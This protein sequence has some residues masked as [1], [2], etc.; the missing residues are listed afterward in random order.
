MDLQVFGMTRKSQIKQAM[1][2][3]PPVIQLREPKKKGE[4][5]QRPIEG[6]IPCFW[7]TLTTAPFRSSLY[8]YY[9]TGHHDTEKDVKVRRKL[10]MDNPHIVTFFSA[11][12]I[13]LIVKY[14][15][16]QMLKLDDYFCVYEWGGGGVMHLHCILWNFESE[17]VEEFDL[18]S[19]EAKKR[20][21]KRLVQRVANF[22]N[23]HVSEWN[24]GKNDDGSWK[25][26]RTESDSLPHPASISKK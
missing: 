22:F 1:T 18:D 4:K 24:F 7:A 25:S 17:H 10:A 26:L 16:M 2:I 20:F 3:I 23:L 9:I 5:Q 21:S 14:L 19:Y 8:A 6:R 11:I 13:E 15:M 12:H